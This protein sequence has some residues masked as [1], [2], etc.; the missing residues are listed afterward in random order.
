MNNMD[1]VDRLCVYNEI[2]NISC[3]RKEGNR[4]REKKTKHNSRRK[5]TIVVYSPA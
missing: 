3:N 2:P 1:R 5:Y 4:E